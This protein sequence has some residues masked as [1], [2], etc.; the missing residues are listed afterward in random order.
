MC[1]QRDTYVTLPGQH[2]VC[3]LHCM[4]GGHSIVFGEA[5]SRTT[6]SMHPLGTRISNGDLRCS[7]QSPLRRRFKISTSQ[8]LLEVYSRFTEICMVYQHQRT[9]FTCGRRASSEEDSDSS[10]DDSDSLSNGGGTESGSSSAASE[11]A[12]GEDSGEVTRLRKPQ[13]IQLKRW[14][15]VERNTAFCIEGTRHERDGVGRGD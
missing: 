2:R 12:S 11:S 7:P 1:G 4:F 10:D 6:Y 9:R 5:T 15:R 13:T 14:R 3:S 8:P